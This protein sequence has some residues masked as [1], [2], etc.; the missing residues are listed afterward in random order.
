[1]PPTH[2]ARGHQRPIAASRSAAP[3]GQRA[4]RLSAPSPSALSARAS[5]RCRRSRARRSSTALATPRGTTAPSRR[6]GRGG[7]C[8]ERKLLEQLA[9]EKD[10]RPSHRGMRD[11]PVVGR[12]EQPA[13][14]SA[15]TAASVR[16]TAVAPRRIGRAPPPRASATDQAAG[17]RG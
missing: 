11:E 6:G 9:D 14:I 17:W 4:R 8:R 16:R 13:A 15:L 12:V 2:D 5:R 1:V 10:W 3:A 7:R